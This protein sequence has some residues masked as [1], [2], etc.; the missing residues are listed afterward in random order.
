M[1]PK[2]KI[3]FLESENSFLKSDINIKQKMIDSIL[4]LNSHLLNHQRCW[5]SE[6]ANNE[7]YQKRIEN[8][9]KK[10]M[11]SPG[12]NKNRG[13]NRNNMNVTARKQNDQHSQNKD[14]NEVRETLK[15]DIII[16]H[17][18]MIEYMNGWGISRSSSVKIRSHPGATTEDIIDYIRPTA[19]K[20]PKM[21]VI[22]SGTNDITN[23]VNILEKIRKVI[24]AIKENEANDEIE[25]V[26]SS[27]IH[28]DLEDGINELN[29]KR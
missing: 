20:N 4:E 29:K 19:Q 1:L 6:N 3:K 25:I 14:K 21:M 24:N 23:K 8:K 18:S 11:K 26:L 22:R 5:V 16:I 17:D 9:E 27:V 28:Q 12:K 13:S 2:E 10:L 7:I 15:K